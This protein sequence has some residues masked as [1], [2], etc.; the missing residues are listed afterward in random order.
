MTS[1]LPLGES[2]VPIMLSEGVTPLTWGTFSLM[3][4]I[5]PGVMYS[6][7]PSPLSLTEI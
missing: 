7:L 2:S 1:K 4:S 5:S 3:A 6:A